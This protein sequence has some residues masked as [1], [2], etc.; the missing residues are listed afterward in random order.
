MEASAI[1]VYICAD[2]HGNH[3][4][5]LQRLQFYISYSKSFHSVSTITAGTSVTAASSNSSCK[6]AALNIIIIYSHNINCPG[7]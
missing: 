5:S 2:T 7:Q 4:H 1:L 6:F 3:Y